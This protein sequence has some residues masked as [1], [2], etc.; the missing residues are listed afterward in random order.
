MGVLGN[1]FLNRA[2]TVIT[3]GYFDQK[4]SHSHLFSERIQG[5]SSIS[6]IT[7]NFLSKIKL[8][9]VERTAVLANNCYHLYSELITRL[10][11]PL[12]RSDRP[13]SIIIAAKICIRI[14]IVYSWVV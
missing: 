13:L 3:F 14:D 12:R 5:K 7:I 9:D 10:L 4:S 11:V 2:V 1:K 6:A 8:N